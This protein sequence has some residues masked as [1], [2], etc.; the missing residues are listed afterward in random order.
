MELD[1]VRKTQ[2]NLLTEGP[3]LLTR[4][5]DQSQHMRN[6]QQKNSIEFTFVNDPFI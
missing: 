6:R 1:Q 3:F 5:Q 4:H 2:L